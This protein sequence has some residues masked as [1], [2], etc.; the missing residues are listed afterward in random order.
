VGLIMAVP[1]KETFHMPAGIPADEV[2][3]VCGSF[4][5][6]GHETVPL[7]LADGREAVLI[8]KA[9]EFCEVF[10]LQLERIEGTISILEQHLQKAREIAAKEC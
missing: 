8:K 9:T 5:R 3:A 6:T 1:N 4:S 7:D 10:N 2:A